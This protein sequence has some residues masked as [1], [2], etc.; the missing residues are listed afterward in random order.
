[1]QR[2]GIAL[3]TLDPSKTQAIAKTI[4]YRIRLLVNMGCPPNCRRNGRYRARNQELEGFQ[5][6]G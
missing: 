1:M 6:R 5:C 3:E 4:A 2:A